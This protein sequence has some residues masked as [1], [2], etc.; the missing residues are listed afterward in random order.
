MTAIK[1]ITK[2]DKWLIGILF[3]LSIFGIISSYIVSSASLTKEAEIRV[4][5]E[6]IKTVS[7][8]EGYREEFRIGG[9]TEYAIIEAQDGKV[10][11]RQDDS[12]RQIGVNTGWVS[13]PTQQVVN[14]PYRIVVTVVSDVNEDVD[15]IAR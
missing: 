14:L 1:T 12:P 9:E 10:R 8:K 4:N 7:L 5:G 3:L 6:L 15:V 2:A 13:N 11:I